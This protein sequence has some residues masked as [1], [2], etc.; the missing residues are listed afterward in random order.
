MKL[1]KLTKREF[2]TDHEEALKMNMFSFN[3]LRDYT[4]KDLNFL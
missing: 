2:V 4:S 1:S 3:K